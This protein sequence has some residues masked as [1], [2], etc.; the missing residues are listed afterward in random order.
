[1]TSEVNILMHM[2]ILKVKN[3]TL[4][5]L[6]F[7]QVMI[8]L[9]SK[10]NMN[11]KHI[12][13]KN[14]YIKMNITTHRE[15]DNKIKKDNNGY[16]LIWMSGNFGSSN[17]SLNL[18][19][20]S[21]KYCGSCWIRPKMLSLWL[22]SLLQVSDWL[23]IVGIWLYGSVKPSIHLMQITCIKSYLHTFLIE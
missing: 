2:N 1:M 4:F 13:N 7:E 8:C 10:S 22:S 21:M 14:E 6:K 12:N 15:L 18:S 17:P 23:T 20:T 3:K 5:A 16:N 19:S 9:D 11:T